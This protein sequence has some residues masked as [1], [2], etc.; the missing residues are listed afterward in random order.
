MVPTRTT[1][2][3]LDR[4]GHGLINLVLLFKDDTTVF[5]KLHY[6]SKHSKNGAYITGLLVNWFT[7]EDFPINPMT[8]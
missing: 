3:V 8:S 6:L 4:I 2:D 5:L 1:F 7:N